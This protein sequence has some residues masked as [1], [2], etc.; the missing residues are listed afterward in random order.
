MVFT[1]DDPIGYIQ[2]FTIHRELKVSEILID[3][4]SRS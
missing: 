1:P 2:R 3:S 4:V